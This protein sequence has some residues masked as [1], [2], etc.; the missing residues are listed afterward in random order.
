[1]PTVIVFFISTAESVLPVTREPR[2]LKDEISSRLI[3]PIAMQFIA[4]PLLPQPSMYLVFSVLFING[5][6]DDVAC[7]CSRTSLKAF[8]IRMVKSTMMR[9]AGQVARIG[10]K[11]NGYRIMVGKPEGKGTLGR[12]KHRWWILERQDGMVWTDGS[13][14]G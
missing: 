11:R 3:S 5:A 1:L 12:P 9:W 2:N 8:V 14:S 6:E 4:I 7:I 13:G 10:E